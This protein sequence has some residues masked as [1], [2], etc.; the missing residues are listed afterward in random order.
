MKN[1]LLYIL[2]FVTML[3]GSMAQQFVAQDD[4]I[5]AALDSLATKKILDKLYAKPLSLKNKFGY[6]PDSIPHFDDFVYE[7]RLAKLDAASPF[8]LQFNATVKPYIDM[9]IKRRVLMSRILGLSQLYY[10][11]FEEI[12][13]KY[14]IPLELKNLAV[15][16]SALNPVARSRAGAMGLWQFMYPT[17][18]LYGLNVTSY[19]DERA[20]PYK[21]T[22]AAA[23]YLQFLYKMFNDW[24]MV[25]AA[26]NAGPGTINRAIRRSGGKKTY[27]EIRPYLPIETQAYVPAFIAANYV[28]NYYPEHNIYPDVPRKTYFELDTVIIKEPLS[29]DQLAGVL[30]VTTEEIQYFNP[31]YKKQVI[32]A[33]G[34]ILTMPKNVIGKFVTNEEEIYAMLRKQSEE[35]KALA[36]TQVKEVQI[37]HTVKAGERLSTIARKYGVTV[38]DITTWNLVGKKGLRPGR[39][40]VIYKVEKPVVPKDSTT[41]KK[42]ETNLADKNATADKKLVAETNVAKT[43]TTAVK[44]EIYTVKPGDYFY[45]IAREHN[46]SVD[47]LLQINGLNRKSTLSAGQK[48]KLTK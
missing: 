30:D 16:E 11:M 37:T 10:P 42:P 7:N 3:S 33:G 14:N 38:G 25:L 46:I 34:N 18:K 45:K 1:R 29:F 27:W 9:Y 5:A 8:D 21:A 13:D 23:E 12:F 39:K 6:A 40:L 19:I 22:V 4:P 48:L 32:P 2:I 43:E 36:Q 17:G 35:Q 15:I 47:D 24:Q 20:D 41:A 28:M 44:E 31:I 26:Y